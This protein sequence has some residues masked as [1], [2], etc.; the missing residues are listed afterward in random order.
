M[1]YGAP[2]NLDQTI[3]LNLTE[4]Q[5]N[6]NL[7]NLAAGSTTFPN[8]INPTQT[9]FPF[10]VTIPAG[11]FIAQASILVQGSDLIVGDGISIDITGL[12]FEATDMAYIGTTPC[13]WSTDFQVDGVYNNGASGVGATLT[14]ASGTLETD[15]G[16]LIINGELVML[17]GQTNQNENGMYVASGVGVLVVLTRS[18]D[19]DHLGQVE[20][21][22]YTCF[23]NL[24]AFGF[25]V[26]GV[27]APFGVGPIT[28]EQR[29]I[30][31]NSWSL[32]G[33]TNLYAAAFYEPAG[34]NDLATAAATS[35]F[36]LTD[37][38]DLAWVAA[39][40]QSNPDVAP[41]FGDN[42]ATFQM[43]LTKLFE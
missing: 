43:I 34:S 33:V 2:F 1:Q 4:S 12:P 32:D 21:G 27:T 31:P 26:T 7:G 16:H 14:T 28:V 39:P 3:V 29:T 6:G 22:G 23:S 40:S 24:N 9:A 42:V 5:A 10:G 38:I 25:V 20:A 30:A 41:D 35:T 11:Q 36:N 17:M 18:T 15:S 13:Q 37:A 19:F 8:I